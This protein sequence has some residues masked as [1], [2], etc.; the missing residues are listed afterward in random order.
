MSHTEISALL[1]ELTQARAAPDAFTVEGARRAWYAF[2]DNFQVPDELSV[3]PDPD[4]RIRLE[5]IRRRDVSDRKAVLYLHGGGYLCGSARSHRVIAAGLAQSFNGVIAS[6]DYRLAP[7][8]PF[9]AQS[10]DAV[11]AFDFL[12][13]DGRVAADIAI[14][15][16]SAG[17]GLALT[18]LLELK[19]SGRM[20]PGAAWC[21][22]SWFD[23]TP[24]VGRQTSNIVQDPIVFP[25]VLDISAAHYL[26]GHRAS[27]PLVSPITADLRGL[28]PLLIQVGS[29]ELLLDDSLRLAKTATA[30]EVDVTLQVWPQMVHAWHLFAPRLSEGRDATRVAAVWLNKVLNS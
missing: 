13:L 10:E 6:L 8:H 29:G 7:E 27:D 25:H 12:L 24:R 2:T 15:G 21:I 26:N 30:A 16:D 17:G 28:P 23:L 14:A 3:A 22:S 19:R 18:L 4:P 20:M 5:W 1:E 11:R 9:P